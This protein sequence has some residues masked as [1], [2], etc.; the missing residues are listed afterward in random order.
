MFHGHPGSPKCLF[1]YSDSQEQPKI[2]T[3][4]EGR[5]V[6]IRMS[7]LRIE[8]GALVVYK[9]HKTGGE[10]FERKEFHI[11]CLS[12]RLAVPWKKW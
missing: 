12:R 6:E 1:P 11:S 2:L 3:I 8:H 7:S 10:S 4:V 5:S 9:N